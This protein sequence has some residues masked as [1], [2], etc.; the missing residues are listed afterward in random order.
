MKINYFLLAITLVFSM[1]VGCEPDNPTPD[2][3]QDTTTIQTSGIL[4]TAPN[5]PLEEMSLPAMVWVLD[6]DSIRFFMEYSDQML[7]I[8]DGDHLE[9]QDVRHSMGDTVTCR[10]ITCVRTDING[11]N[12]NAFNIEN[13]E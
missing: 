11:N 1:V 12:Y 6:V 10:G 5:P 4:N 8:C 9:I 3:P 2:N 7:L 13:W